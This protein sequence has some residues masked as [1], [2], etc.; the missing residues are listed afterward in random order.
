MF[1]FTFDVGQVL[2]L[3]LQVAISVLLPVFLGYAIVAMRTWWGKIKA[4][5]PA[6]QYAFASSLVSQLVLA[7]EQSGLA[8]I[9]A[10]EAEVKKQW[11]IDRAEAELAKLGIKMDLNTIS[12]MIEAAVKAELNRDRTSASG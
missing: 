10:N 8:G 4:Q 5:I 9:I 2:Q 3:V 1:D 7:A 11:V 12:D 6:E